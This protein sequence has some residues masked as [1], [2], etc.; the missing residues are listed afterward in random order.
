MSRPV[1]LVVSFGV[2]VFSNG[3]DLFVSY[4]GFGLESSNNSKDQGSVFEVVEVSFFSF[5]L[6]CL[7]SAE[8]DK[9]GVGV[10]PSFVSD[11]FIS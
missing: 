9:V 4:F 6:F 3:N 1:L 2:L 8:L 11:L 5:I 10:S 7:F